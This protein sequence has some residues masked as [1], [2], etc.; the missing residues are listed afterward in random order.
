MKKL[1]C[2]KRFVQK[3]TTVPTSKEVVK[4]QLK[5]A[6]PECTVGP[7]GK[8]KCVQIQFVFNEDNTKTGCK[9]EL[10][11]SFEKYETVVTN[12]EDCRSVPQEVC[13]D[14]VVKDVEVVPRKVCETVQKKICDR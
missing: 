11:K 5:C 14:V 3:C 13:M 1:E 10:C 4:T 7:Y 12:Q 6:C 9:D 2:E 8:E